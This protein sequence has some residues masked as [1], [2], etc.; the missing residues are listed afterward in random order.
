MLALS[1]QPVSFA[2]EADQFPFLMYNTGV[3]TAPY[4]TKLDHGAPSLGYGT[5]KARTTGRGNQTVAAP[6]A[7]RV[8]KDVIFSAGE[9]GIK[10]NMIAGDHVVIAKETYRVIGMRTQSLTTEDIPADEADTLGD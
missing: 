4:G 5:E 7:S 1:Q 8:S 10:V 3:L 2:I 6:G 9:L